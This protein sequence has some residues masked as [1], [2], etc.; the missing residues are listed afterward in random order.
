MTNKRLAVL[1]VTAAVMVTITA[2]LYSGR[3]AG[4]E[5]FGSGS[6]LIQGLAPEKM[7]SIVIEHGG[8][9][10][11]I[12]R[13]GSGF[14]LAEKDNYPASVKKIN[15]FLIKCLD[16]RCKEKVTESPGN[17]AELGVAEEGAD[18][19]TVSFLGGDG[20]PLIGFI[21]GKSAER[22][23]AYVRLVD[24][25]VVYTTEE[26]LHINTAATD[27]IDKSLVS[28]KRED[29]KRV[30]VQVGKESYAIAR[31]DEDKIVLENIPDGKRPKG[32]EYESVFGALSGLNLVDVAKADR[33]DLKWGATYTCRLKSG[34]T[35]TVQLAEQGEKNYARLS[36]K[37]PAAEILR[38]SAQITRT[39]SDEKLKEKETVLL[40]AKTAGEFAERHAP[41]VYEISSWAAEKL[42]K[43]LAD[44]VEDLPAEESP[45]EVAASHILISYNG[46]NRSEAT[47][48]KAEAKTLAEEVL[49]KARADG[50]DFA[51]LARQYSDG[52]T[53]EKGGD[54]GTF[55][56]GAMDPAFEKAAFGLKVGEISDVVETPFGFHIIKRTK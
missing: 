14:V 4:E 55:K 40:A 11:T 53:K 19:T 23:G 37:G 10:V 13:E 34:L 24:N 47:R 41:W 39:E 32:T 48:E 45:E 15:D 49:A 52:P 3:G 44:L 16:I 8:D 54:L 51:E 50:A 7:G 27:Y 43:P 30:E 28:A 31:D 56:K 6:T 26:Y 9:K 2:A 35:Y 46:A 42:R 21:K 17:H 20:K 25:N 5:E 22:S 29:V 18:A 38:K 1:A 12:E 33:L 36:A